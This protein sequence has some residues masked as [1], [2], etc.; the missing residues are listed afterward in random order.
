MRTSIWFVR[1]GQTRLNKERRYQGTSDSPLTLFGRLQAEALAK[2]LRRI[3][4][5]VAIISPAE[6]TRATAEAILAGRDVPVVADPRWAETNHGRWEGLTYTEVVGRYREEAAARFADPLNGR[7]LG[8]ETLA[9]VHARVSEGWN[10]LL[11]ERPGGRVL[12]VTHATP[13]QL[14]LCALGN[15]PPTQHWRWRIDLGSL[16]A[17]DLYGG[18]PIVR[19]VNEV[20]RSLPPGEQDESERREP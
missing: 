12:V 13:V 8:G 5:T 11:R 1:H 10:A 6:R 18:G 19:V 7:A 4:F 17:L 3:P 2:R 20:P 9:E 14:I 16:T 15:L